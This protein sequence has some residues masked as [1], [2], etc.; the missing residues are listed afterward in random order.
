MSKYFKTIKTG[1]VRRKT[2]KLCKSKSLIYPRIVTFEE[3][4]DKMCFGHGY[5]YFR[6]PKVLKWLLPRVL[7]KFL[8]K[9]KVR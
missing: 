2:C 7:I 9:R 3:Y 6:L 1:G 5:L 8:F 4:Y